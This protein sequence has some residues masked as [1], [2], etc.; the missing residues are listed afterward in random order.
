MGRFGR[1]VMPV[2]LV[3]TVFCR[4]GCAETVTSADRVERIVRSLSLEAKAG[5]VLMGFFRGDSVTPP[6]LS[7]IGRVRPA[8]MILYS[9]TG[10]IGSPEQVADLTRSLQEAAVSAGG[11]P[12]FLAVDQE[13][14]RVN[15][16]TRGVTVFPGNMPLGA[17]GDPE[18]ASKAARVTARELRTLGINANFAPA[19]DVL[20]NPFNPVIGTRSFGSDPALVARMATAMI[21]PTAE[22]GVLCVAKHFPGHGNTSVDSHFGLPVDD[23]PL[24]TLEKVHLAPFAALVKAGVPAIMTAHVAMPGLDRGNPLPAT[25]LPKSYEILREEMGFSGLTVTD[26]LGMKALD[27]YWS[28]EETAVLALQAGADLLVLGADPGHEPEELEKIHRALVFAVQ[29]DRISRSRLDEAVRRVLKAKE[30]LKVLDDPM[31]KTERMGELASPESLALAE[32]IARRAL[33]VVWNRF[34]RFPAAEADKPKILLWPLE[35]A[36]QVSSLLAD[37]AGLKPLFVSLSLR[38]EDFE[39]I[40]EGIKGEEAVYVWAGDLGKSPAWKD[41]AQR[42]GG[43]A[44]LLAV[45]S[46]ASLSLCPGAG[47]AVATYSE[48]PVSLKVL[49]DFLRAPWSPTGKLPVALPGL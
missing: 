28:I 36:G 23:S 48:T 33:T 41:L 13:G 16:L 2:L 8:G 4:P 44:V 31:P 35:K 43:R 34:G 1:A 10:N 7:M 39:G 27:R 37:S 38:P 18:L 19:A 49:G 11:L 30:T 29:T 24:E 32:T 25:L 47:A 22:E 40:L 9:S 17:A 14:G 26:S 15:R 12:L 6:L 45:G 46:P 5:Q 3:L 20:T 42:I 21:A